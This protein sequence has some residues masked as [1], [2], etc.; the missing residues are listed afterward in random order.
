[1]KE[2]QLTKGLVTLIDDGDFDTV[3]KKKWWAEMAGNKHY[4]SAYISKEIRRV[5]LH[6]FLLGITDPKIYVDHID[7][8][9]LNNQRSNLRLCAPQF[10]SHNRIGKVVSTSKYKGVSWSVGR[11]NWVAEICLDGIIYP[12]GGFAIEEEAAEAYNIAASIFFGEFAWLNTIDF[13][14]PNPRI[15]KAP[16]RIRKAK[17][18]YQLFLEKK[19]ND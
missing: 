11:G 17:T 12:I 18:R 7:G 5:R 16:S 14:N 13:D 19:L 8:D 15:G 9:T 6:R 3:S 4:A 2:I 1:M 10:N